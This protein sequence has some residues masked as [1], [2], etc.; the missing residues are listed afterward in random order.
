MGRFRLVPTWHD[1]A[2]R[3]GYRI[4]KKGLLFWNEYGDIWYPTEEAAKRAIEASKEE[5]V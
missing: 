5:D 2:K 3:S 1:E 4:Q